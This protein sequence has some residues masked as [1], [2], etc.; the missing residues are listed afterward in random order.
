MGDMLHGMVVLT[1]HMQGYQHQTIMTLKI[2]ILRLL[3][4]VTMVM[5]IWSMLMLQPNDG[6]ACVSNPIYNGIY[7]MVL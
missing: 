1:V 2:T 3:I 7:Q 4:R 5:F 6:H